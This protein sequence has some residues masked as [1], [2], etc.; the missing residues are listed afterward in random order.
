MMS[1]NAVMT[2]VLMDHALFHRAQNADVTTKTPKIIGAMKLAIS[3]NA[4]Q[5]SS[6]I[7]PDLAEAQQVS[8]PFSFFFRR[9]KSCEV[10]ALYCDACPSRMRI[11]IICKVA[12]RSV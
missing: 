12:T 7:N 5:P 8:F 11:S 6:K 2:L 9:R 3:P 4:V 1:I 10:F